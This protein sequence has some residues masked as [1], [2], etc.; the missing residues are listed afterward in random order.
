MEQKGD[1]Q[2]SGHAKMGGLGERSRNFLPD[3][4]T[5][6]DNLQIHKGYK[7]CGLDVQT[8]SRRKISV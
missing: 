6:F 5:R 3:R 7:N 2:E 4:S 1:L 8:K